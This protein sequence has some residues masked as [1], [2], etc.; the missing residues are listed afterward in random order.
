M[1]YTFLK[2]FNDELI[3]DVDRFMYGSIPWITIQI[4][5]QG[6]IIRRNWLIQSLLLSLYA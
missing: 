2:R 5:E 6:L 3:I 1:L 4:F